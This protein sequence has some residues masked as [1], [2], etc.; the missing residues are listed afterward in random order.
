ML[1]AATIFFM[2]I[3]KV[4]MD[5]ILDF[6]I[7]SL[8]SLTPEIKP[9]KTRSS[10]FLIRPLLTKCQLAHLL[11]KWALSEELNLINKIW[12]KLLKWLLDQQSCLDFHS[13]CPEVG[14]DSKTQLQFK[15]CHW[16]MLQLN[17]KLMKS[18]WTSLHFQNSVKTLFK[19]P[20]I[21]T[22]VATGLSSFKNSEPITFIKSQ[23][24]AEQLKK[25]LTLMKVSQR[26]KVLKLISTLQQRQL[27]L[28]SLVMLLLIGTNIKE[29]SITVRKLRH[30]R[31]NFTLVDNL[32][33][34]ETFMTGKPKFLK[35]QCQLV[36]NCS[37]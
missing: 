26:W 28:N 32:Q 6:T 36:T 9:L 16:L 33:E 1:E 22:H 37:H 20:F 24:V 3:L 12:K 21:P 10:L 19:V 7:Q 17:A 30:L 5:L 27:L 34:Q 25:L 29:V 2:V 31:L 11:Q 18:F 14:K 13:L 35:A 23:W 4:N 15:K 8:I